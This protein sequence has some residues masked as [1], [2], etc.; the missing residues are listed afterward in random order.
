MVALMLHGLPNKC[1][2]QELREICSSLGFDDEM[3]THI[4]V[5]LRR[6]HLREASQRR[7]RKPLHRGY[8][9]VTCNSQATAEAFEQAIRHHPLGSRE[10]SRAS[11]FCSLADRPAEADL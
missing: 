1:M 9:F 7:Q 6:L 5:P 4:H 11:V 3:L 8:A 10:D 2:E